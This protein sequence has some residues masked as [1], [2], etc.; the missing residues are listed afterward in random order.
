MSGPFRL[1]DDRK[2][3]AAAGSGLKTRSEKFLILPN[4][5]THFIGGRLGFEV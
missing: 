2:D 4:P 3:A 1:I 5:T